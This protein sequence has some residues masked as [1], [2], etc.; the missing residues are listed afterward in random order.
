VVD[1]GMHALKWDREKALQFLSEHTTLTKEEAAN[2]I[3]RYLV[4]PGQALGYM[5]GETEIFRLRG[6]AEK[7]LGDRFDSKDFHEVALSHGAVPLAV[8][9]KLVGQ[10]MDRPAAPKGSGGGVP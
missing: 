4:M 1:T 2:E 6:E 3:D 8:L 9:G 10:W 7:K 5:I